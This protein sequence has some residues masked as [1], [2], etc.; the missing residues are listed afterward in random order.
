ME[1]TPPPDTALARIAV[2]EVVD[3]EVVRTVLGPGIDKLITRA[4]AS[5]ARLAAGI[6]DDETMALAVREAELLRDDGKDLL[7]KY[8][9]EFYVPQM[10]V[11]EDVRINIFDDRLKK[12]TA[13]MKTLMGYVSDYKT[14]KARE[15]KLAKE[16]AEAEAR[17]QR[18]EA[19]A[20]QREAVAA[21]ARAKQAAE[22]EKRRKEE[23][24]AA[25]AR[26][27]QAEK[28]AQERRER[29]AREAAAAETSRKLAEEEEARIKHAEVAQEVGN[30]AAKVDTILD[31]ATPISPVLGK[32]EQAKSLEAVRLE[33]ENARKVAEEKARQESAAAAEAASKRAAAEA[34]AF[35]LRQ[36]ADQATAAAAATA[37]AAAA[38]ATEVAKVDSGT[39][40]TVR[41]VWDLDSDGTEMGDIAS[42]MIILK[43]IIDGIIPIEYCGFNRNRPQDWRASIIQKDVTEKKDRFSVKGIR[44]LPQQDE[45]LNRRVVGGRR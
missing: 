31:S 29:E 15:E 40:G 16:R 11:L 44:A 41:W 43:Q 23:A 37:S 25:E 5:V 9:E 28:E 13:H 26:R 14:R 12:I 22:E 20:K 39:T 32:A 45:R 7:E 24:I 34:E 19:E 18:E 27:V 17:R 30:G 10:R 36:E 42:V 3:L 21:E 1:T 38:A 6:K 8:R 33:Q 4:N 35:R 2:P